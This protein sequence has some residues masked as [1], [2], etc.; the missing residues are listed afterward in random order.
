MSYVEQSGRRRHH[1]VRPQRRLGHG[2]NSQPTASFSSMV[3]D[4]RLVAGAAQ[5]VRES[6]AS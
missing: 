3:S 4:S 1:R 2:F 6:R 5:V